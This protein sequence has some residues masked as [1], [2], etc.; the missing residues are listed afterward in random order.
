MASLST[1]LIVLYA[2]FKPTT[3]CSFVT[4]FIT[5]GIVRAATTPIIASVM[6]TS[7]NVKAKWGLSVKDFCLSLR[8]RER[9][10]ESYN[11]KA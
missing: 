11:L 9:E 3:Y 10:R 2:F 4:L 6:S 1:D 8:E 5:A 7:A